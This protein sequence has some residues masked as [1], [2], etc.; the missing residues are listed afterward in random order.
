MSSDSSSCCR[1]AKKPSKLA[2]YRPVI[3][4]FS[5]CLLMALT[6]SWMSSEKLPTLRVAELFIAFSMCVLGIL[7]LQDLIAYAKSFAQ[8]DLLARHFHKYG[9]FY[10]FAEAIGGAFMIAG[11]FTLVVAPLILVM[12]TIGAISVFK[13]VYLEKKELN[14]ACVGGNSQVPLGLISLIENLMMMAMSI[15]MLLK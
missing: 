15:W 14:C 6:T 8:Y 2:R 11:L 10:P 9:Y 13:A 5:I 3:A 1:S 12:T 4:L 7:K